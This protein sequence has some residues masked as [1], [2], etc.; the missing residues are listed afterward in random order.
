MASTT[1]GSP[2]VQS[3]DLVSAW[4]TASLSVADRI[5][6]VSFKGNG[7][8]N[9]TASYT[10]VLLDA[11][12]TVMMNV[13]SAN[14][15]TIPASGTVAYELGTML[16]VSN[17][18][19]GVTTVQP[20][21]GVVLNGGNITL[22]QYQ[23]ATVQLVAADIWNVVATPPPA[24]AQGLTLI[25]T[26]TFVTQ[27]TVSINNCFSTTYEN[28]L[29]KYVNS[30]ASA[31]SN[32]LMRLRVGGVDASG[33]TDYTRQAL[34]S[35]GGT[36]VGATQTN[37]QWQFAGLSS[38]TPQTVVDMEIFSPFLAAKTNATTRNMQYE[39]AGAVWQSIADGHNH[40]QTTS[41][42]GFTLFPS[43]GTFSGKIFVYGYQKA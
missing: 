24:A 12:K 31:N 9:Q 3:S 6:D 33:A 34:L 38:G 36:V 17:K 1:Y 5:D 13:A 26:N 4:P 28:Y 42:D 37:P 2:Y 27:S 10:G 25:T 32:L 11:G 39:G 43:S 35:F 20:A 23:S 18:G 16:R 41:Y 29:I 14:N 21:V 30:A 40:N 15:F 22:A 7:L 8:N 19:A